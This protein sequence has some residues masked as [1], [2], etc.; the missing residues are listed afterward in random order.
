MTV[1]KRKINY[2]ETDRMGVTHHSNYVRFMEEARVD[3]LER[4]GCSYAALEEMGVIS[5]VLS[6]SCEYKESTT[7]GDELEVAVS[8]VEYNGV[9]MKFEY[10][11]TK[12]SGTRQVGFATSEHCFLSREGRVLIV[13]RAYPELHA[14]L[15]GLLEAAKSE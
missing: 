13:K 2:Y 12:E 1:Y 3:F 10:R 14:A 9:K 5:P 7:F 6:V 8:L 4:Q 15:G 11:M